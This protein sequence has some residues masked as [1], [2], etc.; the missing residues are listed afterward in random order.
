MSISIYAQYQ[1]LSWFVG[2]NFF[3]DFS[4]QSSLSAPFPYLKD[5][6]HNI[7]NN[8]SLA[9]DSNGVTRV[10][11]YNN[12]IFLPELNGNDAITT[13]SGTQSP[14]QPVCVLGKE[15]MDFYYFSVFNLS[16]T[17]P[18]Q[19]YNLY[20][21]NGF[22]EQ[23]A[24]YTLNNDN[25]DIGSNL[26]SKMAV[27]F[28]PYF[29]DTVI[30]VHELGGA[31]FRFY[32]GS[33][34]GSY[35]ISNFGPDYGNFAGSS[36]DEGYMKFSS[37]GL[38]LAVSSPMENDLR[39]YEVDISVPEI[40]S[41]FFVLNDAPYNAI[42]FAP[43]DNRILYAATNDTIYQIFKENAVG[44]VLKTPIATTADGNFENMQVA[45]DGKIYVAKSNANSIGVI[46]NP[47][48]LGK[49]CYYD[50]I[51]WAGVDFDGSLPAF[52]ANYFGDKI[53][54]V[55]W[56]DFSGEVDS[57]YVDEIVDFMF[58]G[59]TIPQYIDWYF[60]DGNFSLNGSTIA[61]HTYS[62]AG[63]YDLTANLKYSSDV[64]FWDSVSIRKK[65]VVYDN[66]NEN[67]LYPQDSLICDTLNYFSMHINNNYY[68]YNFQIVRYIYGIPQ[69][70]ILTN[71]TIFYVNQPGE[72]I[73]DVLDGGNII[74]K[75]T[76]YIYAYE[77]NLYINGEPAVSGQT[78]YAEDPMSFE[79]TF[80]EYPETFINFSNLM[81][82]WHFFDG[83]NEQSYQNVLQIDTVF[84]QSGSQHIDI[85][86]NYD[87]CDNF[88]SYD[89][90]I[91]PAQDPLIYPQDTTFCGSS[92][93]LEAIWLPGENY[94][95]TNS[96]GD[97]L[98]EG[99]DEFTLTVDAADKYFVEIT[100][101]ANILEDSATVFSFDPHFEVAGNLV[102]GS[103]LLFE[104]F[105]EA[106]PPI[107][108]FYTDVFYNWDFGDGNTQSAT[109]NNEVS[110]S[111]NSPGNY[112]VSL[113]VNIDDCEYEFLENI[114]ITDNQLPYILQ[115]DTIL[116]SRGDSILLEVIA[117]GNVY[118]FEWFH[119]INDTDFKLIATDTNLIYVYTPGKFY[120]ECYDNVNGTTMQDSVFIAYE[121]CENFD[122]SFSAN[123]KINS[124]VCFDNNE[125]HFMA[126][127]EE[128]PGYCPVSDYND[129]YFVWDF[130]DG[131]VDEGYGM[132][133]TWHN[134]EVNG[135]Y[136]STLYVFDKKN[137]EKKAFKR[138]KIYAGI[139]DT[140][141]Y[142][143]PKL[144]ES[145]IIIDLN[146]IPELELDFLENNRFISHLDYNLVPNNPSEFEL[147]INSSQIENV[148]NAEDVLLYINFSGSGNLE[149]TLTSPVYSEIDVVD[150]SSD[151][152]KLFGY[153]AYYSEENDLS[154]LNT[155]FLSV[156]DNPLVNNS[157]GHYLYNYFS[158]DNVYVED[159]LMF[160][161][162]GVYKSNGMY[163]FED[164]PVNGDWK[165]KIQNSWGLGQGYGII[166][167]W[168]LI[169][170]KE[171]FRINIMPDSMVC[172]DQFGYEY[173]MRNKEITINNSGVPEYELKC[174]VKYPFSD[175]VFEKNLVILM[176]E[177]LAIPEYFS[178][179]GDGT[180]DF[181]RPVSPNI[182]A[183]IVVLDKNG[184]IVADYK[185]TEKP[186]GWDGYFNGK[187]L[188]SDSYWYIITLSDGQI[189]KGVITIVR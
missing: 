86:T 35:N 152:T 31:N 71:D 59:N 139:P 96:I 111:Y 38:K 125:I 66:S 142:D 91:A 22:I 163:D 167:S 11:S 188:P 98:L 4:Q 130:G 80:D 2:E 94:V 26:S 169:F 10:L 65:V 183:D 172:T 138:I 149:I 105:L 87:I 69:D 32:H 1:S 189:L 93:E 185:T 54:L 179:N 97:T 36:Y 156:R 160:Y 39:I 77:A 171:Y 134:Y 126:D 103:E 102:V 52:P 110:Y 141:F 127:I 182:D 9:T 16:S 128:Y 30:A 137:C 18:T 175:C 5:S 148:Q 19:G 82:D 114:T 121:V 129:L 162:S 165:M 164:E 100:D 44:T 50:E 186:Y 81:T 107:F 7:F 117:P 56:S 173:N 58:D 116:C 28:D 140:I 57:V 157:G 60:G 8:H 147:S 21:T 159:D 47:Q 64:F 73:L 168:G 41:E 135:E 153:P 144:P 55:T 3:M 20:F 42:E 108:N 6:T 187:P 62:A 154:K 23:N 113:T 115:D 53:P 123:D 14:T 40:I 143:Y 17:S 158:P 15:D 68:G 61:G 43:G 46:I 13:I 161:P 120:V 180:N 33:A 89:I 176:P 119:K 27:Y 78:Y 174:D 118:S 48:I 101:G 76:A 49:D 146:N 170:N 84:Y 133:E 12:E 112:E 99:V 131:N 74:K 45:A 37:N 177:E 24:N 178:P 132:I 150:V 90:Y 88:M 104:A 34:S 145:D 85:S 155:Y 29:M 184:R 109:N 67:I 92:I 166:K 25:N 51:S 181:W 151:T 136:F 70:T 79:L 106:N 95:W 72:Y 122:V 63:T 124:N 83:N 75:D